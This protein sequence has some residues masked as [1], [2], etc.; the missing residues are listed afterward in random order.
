MMT[1]K[2]F[3][4]IAIIATLP[5]QCFAG[6][7]CS[8][9]Y[10]ISENKDCLAIDR[11]WPDN[12]SVWFCGT[13][14]NKKCKGVNADAKHTVSNGKSVDF[15]GSRYWCCGGSASGLG[16]FKQGSQWS[17]SETITEQLPNGG[18]C[19]WT[20][21]KT[22]CDDE[23]KGTKCTKAECPNSGEIFRNDECIKPCADGTVFASKT[24]NACIKCETNRYQG[25][26]HDDDYN[27]TC[28]QCDDKTQLWINGRGECINK[29]N[30]IAYTTADM[31]KCWRCNG[32]D[33]F[34]ACLQG[35]KPHKFCPE[36]YTTK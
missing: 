21:T 5:L 32:A 8:T 7:F 13:T 10:K 12:N 15:N 31:K 28:I 1:L 26:G 18:T 30:M 33:N 6:L 2:K 34:K 23:W 22:I 29:A 3:L 4:Y 9:E 14:S 25:I 20:R 19:T 24:S 35:K 11:C 36:D 27:P 17:Q 16:P